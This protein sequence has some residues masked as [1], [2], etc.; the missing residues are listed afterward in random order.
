MEDWKIGNDKN[1][2]KGR[3][4]EDRKIGSDRTTGKAE[5]W[6][7]GRLATTNGRR[8]EDWKIRKMDDKINN[9]YKDLEIWKDSIL[10]I[11]EVY[12]IINVIPKAEEFNLKLQLRRAVTSIALNIAEGKGRKS[13]KD[14]ANF[15]TIA[16][17]SLMEVQAILDICVEL[18]YIKEDIKVKQS[19]DILSRRINKLRAF[20][21]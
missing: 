21:K 17:G 15:L 12:K 13:K 9:N 7:I 6:K 2:K 19:I 18:G 10:L 20:L 1:D 16:F 3:R 5:D 4:L 11:K 8:I 14:F